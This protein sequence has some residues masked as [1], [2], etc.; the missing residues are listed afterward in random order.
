MTSVNTSW[1]I[2]D[3]PAH[4]NGNSFQRKSIPYAADDLLPAAP[5]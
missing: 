3:L 2:N 4:F 1:Q 5:P